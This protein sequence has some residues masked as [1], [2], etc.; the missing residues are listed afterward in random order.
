M[1]RFTDLNDALQATSFDS[2]AMGAA[3]PAGAPGF[4]VTTREQQFSLETGQMDP[5]FQRSIPLC[6]R[7]LGLGTHPDDLEAVRRLFPLV[8]EGFMLGVR[9]PDDDL[10]AWLACVFCAGHDFA[11]RHASLVE[12]MLP[13]S[14][15]AS[16][17]DGL[18]LLVQAS[19]EH[20][21]ETLRE[22]FARLTAAIRTHPGREVH[23]EQ[24]RVI[25]RAWR[26]GLMAAAVATQQSPVRQ[27]IADHLPR[28]RAQQRNWSL[29]PWLEAAQ[30]AVGR[31]PLQQMQHV[32]L[33]ILPGFYGGR[34]TE[35]GLVGEFIAERLA[36]NLTHEW[37]CE[38][39]AAALLD[40]LDAGVE[41]GRRQLE[42]NPERV[43]Q[44]CRELG[45]RCRELM[46]L[47][48]RG[49]R[50]ARGVNAARLLG[51]VLRYVEREWRDARPDSR[52]ESYRLV[53]HVI[54]FGVWAPWAEAVRKHKVA[55]GF[56]EPPCS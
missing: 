12:R 20:P 7:V 47:T 14:A 13:A 33:K 43:A 31:S 16:T 26:G 30:L 28:H 11:N 17:R 36:D 40:W 42:A 23:D 52:A 53:L 29:K 41:Y 21:G 55:V 5:Y 27:L 25:L 39:G 9:T 51:P 18:A 8:R 38:H 48:C 49:V 15:R 3:A 50:E 22:T 35:A 34:A 1:N 2:P 24:A 6:D 10:G 46:E 19:Q 4:P 56:N 32:L 54:D 37:E 44:A 45:P